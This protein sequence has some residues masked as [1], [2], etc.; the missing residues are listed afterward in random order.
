M[1]NRPATPTLDRVHLPADMK[2]LSDRELKLL[3]DELRAEQARIGLSDR[4]IEIIEATEVVDMTDSAVNAIRRKK[5]SSIAVATDMVRDGR[6]DAVVSAGH[7]GAA[8][9]ASTVRRP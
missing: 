9:A 4:R 3:A 7:T 6:A 5:N 1:T 2:A 8:V